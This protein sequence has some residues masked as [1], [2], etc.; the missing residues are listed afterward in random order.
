MMKM[1]L[2]NIV[3]SE[4][5]AFQGM[6]TPDIYYEFYPHLYP[7]RKGISVMSLHYD[8]HPYISVIMHI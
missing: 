3:E 4:I 8:N 1:K 6:D 2:Y 5:Q 7:G